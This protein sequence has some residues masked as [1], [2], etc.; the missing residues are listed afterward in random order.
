[1]N[2]D[3]R[4]EYREMSPDGIQ[5]ALKNQ[6]MI[7]AA[8]GPWEKFEKSIAFCEYFFPREFKNQQR[9]QG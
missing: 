8:K 6:S 7:T 2:P 4:S 3:G 1:L 5:K 9:N